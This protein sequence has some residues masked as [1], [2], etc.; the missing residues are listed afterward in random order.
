MDTVLPEIPTGIDPV[1]GMTV[2]ITDTSR[3]HD[4][5]GVT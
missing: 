4:H 3:E 5:M 2:K 1:C